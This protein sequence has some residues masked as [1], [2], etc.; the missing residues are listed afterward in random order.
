MS[1]ELDRALLGQTQNL[2]PSKFTLDRVSVNEG[3]YFQPKNITRNLEVIFRG[4][5]QTDV[6]EF[7]I[8]EGWIQKYQKDWR[9]KPVMRGGD[10]VLGPKLRGPVEVYYKV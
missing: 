8:S 5:P 7:C 4:I 9:G 2:A 6:V 3:P 1:D 10:Y